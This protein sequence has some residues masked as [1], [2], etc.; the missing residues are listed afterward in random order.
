MSSKVFIKG[1]LT[2][3]ILKL[4]KDNGRMYGYEITKKV[5][6]SSNDKM[7]ISE[8]ALYPAL[9]KLVAGGLL[10]TETEMTDGRVRKYYSLT[11]QG[12]KQTSKEIE[13][14]KEAIASLSLILNPKLQHG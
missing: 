9:H 1:S 14:L 13:M 8:A 3:I 4:L 12:K 6:E 11:K 2:A 10:T 7:N 5:K